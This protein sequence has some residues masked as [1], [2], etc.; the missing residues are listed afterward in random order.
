MC[1]GFGC[2]AVQGVETFS[3]AAAPT[4]EASISWSDVMQLISDQKVTAVEFDDVRAPRGTLVLC[5][6]YIG[7]TGR[8]DVAATT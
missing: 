8:G 3:G 5:R 2:N 6:G 1:F 4:D 7:G